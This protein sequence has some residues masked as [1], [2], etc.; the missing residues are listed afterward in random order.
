MVKGL[1]ATQ[2]TLRA[3]REQGRVA[4]IV[5][6]RIPKGPH[7][8]F[9]LGKDFLGIIDI[10]ALDPE[11]GVVGIQSCSQ[12][13]SEHYKKMTV[14]IGEMSL[15]WIRTPGTRLELWEWR[16]LKYKRGGK[17]MVWTPRI[18]VFTE[19]DFHE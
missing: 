1:S 6:R 11:H 18:H 17:L 9:G 13:F 19:E 4:D 16:K 3:L 15:A 8:P 14:E 5:E 12:T 7:L 10:I 2:R